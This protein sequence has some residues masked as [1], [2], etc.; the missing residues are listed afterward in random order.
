M[1]NNSEC[2]N[3]TENQ[4]DFWGHHLTNAY[5]NKNEYTLEEKILSYDPS[6]IQR[7]NISDYYNNKSN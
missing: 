1:D 2:S 5:M 4:T 3:T 7:L 6:Q